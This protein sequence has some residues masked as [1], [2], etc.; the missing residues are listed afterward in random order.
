MIVWWNYDLQIPYRIKI[1]ILIPSKDQ[2]S[3]LIAKWLAEGHRPLCI[4]YCWFYICHHWRLL[5]LLHNLK[6]NQNGKFWELELF[7]FLSKKISSI[8]LLSLNYYLRLFI[9][10]YLSTIHLLKCHRPQTRSLFNGILKV[11][12]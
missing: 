3:S 12:F 8:L 11:F 1:R 5:Q 10:L 6:G 4:P 9:L 7:T 2:I